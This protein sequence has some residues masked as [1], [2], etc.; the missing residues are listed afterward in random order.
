M[1]R[2]ETRPKYPVT[3]EW[4]ARAHEA[5]D[6]LDLTDTEIAQR[7]GD[8]KKKSQINRLLRGLHRT[9]SLV[10]DVSGVLGIRGPGEVPADGE[11]RALYDVLEP[12]DRHAV[13]EMMRR[14]A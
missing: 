9:S 11:F 3:Q 2:N 13:L 14:L 7:L 10:M 5:Q 1:P 4:L 6:R 12:E 8:V